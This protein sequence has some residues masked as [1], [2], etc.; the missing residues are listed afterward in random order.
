MKFTKIHAAGSDYLVF[1]EEKNEPFRTEQICRLLDRR[2][3]VGA[4]G[5]IRLASDGRMRLYLPSGEERTGDSLAVLAAARYLLDVRRRKS[6][7]CEIRLGDVT[8]TVKVSV[9]GER[10]LC[11][12][13]DLP[14]ITPRPMD[15]MKYYYGIRGEV[16]RACL[17][18]PRM[19]IYTLC[20]EHVVFLIESCA[21]LRKLNLGNICKRL[22]EVLF[23]GEDP[24]LHFAALAGEDTLALRSWRCRVGEI[25]ASGE[26]AAVC[27]YA[28]RENE[29][30]DAARV[31]VRTPG[32][33]VCTELCGKSVSVCAKCEVAF[34][35]EF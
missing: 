35:G 5:L 30:T 1:P 33:T 8:Y 27:A 9:M 25:G 2:L 20:G 21:A 7:L 14:P 23:Y 10:V 17:V 3:G 4:D 18:Q 26:G 22:E 19:H 28:A 29:W 31:L 16:L 6:R 15:Q 32:G 11:V 34:D 24:L 12:W 13:A